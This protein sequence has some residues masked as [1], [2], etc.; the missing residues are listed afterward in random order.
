MPTQLYDIQYHISGLTRPIDWF[1]YQ[2]VHSQWGLD[3]T[4]Q[5]FL[6]F[7]KAIH[8]LLSDLVSHI[9]KQRTSNMFRGISSFCG[10]PSDELQSYLLD[11]RDIVDHIELAQAVQASIRRRSRPRSNRVISPQSSSTAASNISFGGLTSSG[12]TTPSNTTTD[13]TSIVHSKSA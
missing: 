13:N 2:L 1:A 11:P 9:T 12:N 8:E 5:R 10:P 6:E 7:V 3:T 4:R